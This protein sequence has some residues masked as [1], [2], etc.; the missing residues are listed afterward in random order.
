MRLTNATTSANATL[1]V[2]IMIDDTF[3]EARHGRLI[4]TRPVRSEEKNK[5]KS[6]LLNVIVAYRD[7]TRYAQVTR[8][9]FV[10]EMTRGEC[11]HDWLAR[12]NA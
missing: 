3:M 7:I 11:E 12:V 8:R 5:G 1:D 2:L 4:R 9:V 10:N 6:I